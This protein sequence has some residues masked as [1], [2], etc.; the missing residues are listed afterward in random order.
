MPCGDSLSHFLQGWETGVPGSE[1]LELRKAKVWRTG[2]KNRDDVGPG[3][4]PE[5]RREVGAWLTAATT[6]LIKELQV[7][8]Q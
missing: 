2:L 7:L 5:G 1:V 3:P 8:T 6:L 4:N